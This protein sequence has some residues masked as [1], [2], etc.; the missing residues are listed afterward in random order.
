M[1]AADVAVVA[2]TGTTVPVMPCFAV[3]HEEVVKAMMEV[4]R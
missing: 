1:I 4:V 3:T 2:V